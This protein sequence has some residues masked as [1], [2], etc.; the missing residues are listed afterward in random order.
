MQE[1]TDYLGSG[2]IALTM[3]TT[4]CRFSPQRTLEAKSTLIGMLC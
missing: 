1:G 3:R 2:S 4:V